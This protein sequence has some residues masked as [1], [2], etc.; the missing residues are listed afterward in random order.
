MKTWLNLCSQYMGLWH[1]VERYPTPFQ[2]G[3]CNNAFYTLGD[4]EVDVYNTQVLNEQLLTINGVAVPVADGKL[5]VSFPVQN[6]NLTTETDYWVLSTDY[7]SYSLV[8]SCRNVNDYQQQVTFWKLSRNKQLSTEA[9]G[10]IN[11]VI[12]TV[13]VLSQDFFEATNQSVEACFYYPDPQPGVPVQFP[14]TCETNIPVVPNFTYP[15]DPQEG[16]CINHQFSA[17]TGTA[18]LNFVSS[19]VED[20][21]LG[22]TNGQLTFYAGETGGRF[23]LSFISN[24]T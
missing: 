12:G 7:S 21:L 24:G 10:L 22:S 15:K 2:S 1:D 23:T 14:G 3:S 6:T 13:D 4:G 11:A 20:Q 5:V 18:A 16:Q 19:N 8:Y 9:Q 17:G